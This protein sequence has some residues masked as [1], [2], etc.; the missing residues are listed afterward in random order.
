M[1]IQLVK[2]IVDNREPQELVEILRKR[3][4]EVA[5]QQLDVGDYVYAAEDSTKSFVVERK[6]WGDLIASFTEE[7][8]RLF[9]QLHN[10]QLNKSA[11]RPMLIVVGDLGERYKI[12]AE[13]SSPGNLLRGLRGVVCSIA[14]SFQIP[15]IVVADNSEFVDVLISLMNQAESPP[16]M[17]PVEFR[18]RYKTVQ[19]QQE[20]MLTAIRGVGMKTAKKILE[21][22]KTI[23]EVTNAEK[24][25]LEAYA[26]LSV[27]EKVYNTIHGIEM[28]KVEKKK[29]VKRNPRRRY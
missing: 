18:K 27:G 9:E 26:G 16:G 13:R 7:K 25:D 3:E 14:Y 4:V 21:K 6:T 11:Y 8:P 15:T 24:L 12:V 1:A 10:L 28:E 5:L 23:K 17:R 2:M 22:Y 19:E 29:N 20:D